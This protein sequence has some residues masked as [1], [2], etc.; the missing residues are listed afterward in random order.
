MSTTNSGG[1]FFIDA[2]DLTDEQIAATR[3][4]YVDHALEYVENYERKIGFLEKALPYTV[5]PFLKFYKKHHLSGSILFA[6]CGSGRDAQIVAQEGMNIY[7]I[8]VS[9][10]MIDLARKFGVKAQMFEMDLLN[11]K[12]PNAFFS[13]IFCE[14]ALSQIKRTDLPQALSIFANLLTK[15]GIALLGFRNGNGQVFYTQEPSGEKRYG[16]TFTPDELNK[17]ITSF[18]F[19]ILDMSTSPHP[20]KGR[21]DF[22]DFVVQKNI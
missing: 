17:L 14:T 16:T 13:G 6:G 15:S 21:P 5:Q 18:G 1:C 3:Q 4:S 11:L 10:S 19:T 2:T 12:F 9:P 22:I 7:A 20:I 8:D